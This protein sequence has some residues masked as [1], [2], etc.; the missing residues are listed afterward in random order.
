[1]NN[2]LLGFFL[3]ILILILIEKFFKKNI[4]IRLLSVIFFPWVFIDKT[5][6]FFYINFKEV[7]IFFISLFFLRDFIIPLKKTN[8]ILFNSFSY[9][10]LITSFIPI[11]NLFFFYDSISMD[12]KIFIPNF[13][14]SII[15][16]FYF[17][18]FFITIINYFNLNQIILFLKKIYLLSFF[19]ILEF[20]LYLLIKKLGYNNLALIIKMYPADTF[21]S[22][23]LY[24]HIY[25]THFLCL[26]YFLGLYFIKNKKIFIVPNFFLLLMIFYNFE[27]RLTII[28]FL[29]A[30]ITWL[31][32][33]IR[34]NNINENKFLY[35]SSCAYLFLIV[36]VTMVLQLDYLNYLV[37]SV[38]P[39]KISIY[40]VNIDIWM[41]P[42]IDRYNTNIFF[43][44]NLISNNFFGAG[45][46][47]AGLFTYN[48]ELIELK[49]IYTDISGQDQLAYYM[50]HMNFFANHHQNIARIHNGILNLI[51][52]FGWF[53]IIIFFIYYKI[54]RN[55]NLDLK[56][57]S[58]FKSIILIIILFLTISS[59]INYLYEIEIIFLITISAYFISIKKN[60]V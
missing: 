41:Q 48:N 54:I 39:P 4:E 11:F 17:T 38:S 37:Q 1:M 8:K 21:R 6:Y 31:I 32:L 59:S 7:Y 19:I 46:N 5:G 25:T 43:I 35:L 30:K 50:N 20:F 40:Q 24:G 55:L 13:I 58:N 53:N 42:L 60:E 57:Q 15:I 14:L 18:V 36:F 56:T 27:T 51:A 33:K 47:I 9:L 2:S 28:S 12:K 22:I 44:E 23:F 29:I 3:T 26:I 10:T 34:K 16:P 49:K 52:S 45:Y